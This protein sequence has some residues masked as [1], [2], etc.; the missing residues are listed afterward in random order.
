MKDDSFTKTWKKIIAEANMTLDDIKQKKQSMTDLDHLVKMLLLLGFVEVEDNLYTCEFGETVA[1]EAAIKFCVKIKEDKKDC[2]HS[3]IE[4]NDIDGT[5]DTKIIAEYEIN[6][7]FEFITTNGFNNE[8]CG[9][10]FW[11]LFTGLSGENPLDDILDSNGGSDDFL[12]IVSC[13]A[14]DSFTK[15]RIW[16]MRYDDME[17]DTIK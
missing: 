17:I 9:K 13:N 2:V 3:W 4:V 5:E 15:N 7:L 11:S 14:I 16:N 10:L 12:T 8:P 6:D 1:C